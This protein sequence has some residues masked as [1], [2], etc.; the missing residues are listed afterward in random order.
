M[1]CDKCELDKMRLKAEE[2]NL[3]LSVRTFVG[4][5]GEGVDVFVG[6]PS[7]K[8]T[9]VKWLGHFKKLPEEHTCQNKKKR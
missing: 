6:K 8:T 2:N 7:H 1:K 5:P 3:E 4:W 9:V